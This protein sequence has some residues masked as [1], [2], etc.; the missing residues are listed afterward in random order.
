MGGSEEVA[1]AAESQTT[2]QQRD[3]E[4]TYIGQS[5]WVLQIAPKRYLI[6]STYRHNTYGGAGVGLICIDGPINIDGISND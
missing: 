4:W 1:M 2:G 6:R 5:T 3:A